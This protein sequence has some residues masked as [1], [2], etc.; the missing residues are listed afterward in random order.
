MKEK[1]LGILTSISWNSQ[2]WADNPSKNDVKKSKYKQ[3]ISSEYMHESLNFGYEKY[4]K[5]PDD[6]FIAY[7]PMLNRKPALDNSK[8]VKIIFFMSFNPINN[9]KYIVGFYGFPTF[10]EKYFRTRNCE[11]Y[12]EYPKGNIKSHIDNIVYLENYLQVDKEFKC[13]T[14]LPIGKLVSQRGFNYLNWHH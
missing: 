7:S 13:P 12:N 2:K 8:F 3:V 6:T 10:G 1:N 11:K 5:E 4:L 9:K 14:F